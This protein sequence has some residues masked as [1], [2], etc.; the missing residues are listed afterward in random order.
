MKGFVLGLLAATLVF[1]AY[2][3]VQS[4]RNA[5]PDE[6]A[7]GAP[8]AGAAAKKRKKRM[9]GASRVARGSPGSGFLPGPAGMAPDPEPDPVRLSAADLRVVGQGD[10]LGRPDVV[11][12][13]MSNDKDARELTQEDIDARFR[14]EESAI[15]GCISAARP[16]PDTYVPG[17]VT[18]KFRI[19]RTGMVRGVR[20][21]AP[22]V[23]HKGGL[24][25]CVKNVVG[26]IH[27]PAA[28][29]SQV[30]SYPFT[31]S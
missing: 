31:L 29:S 12:M 27:F 17:R 30:V 2:L 9:R 25:G 7:R 1:S 10:D 8:D 26:R 24:Y 18:I 28:G 16:D 23:L 14:P 15:L 21:D 20:V 13:D 5:S 19:Q 6:V 22:A 11:R 4:R 3:Y